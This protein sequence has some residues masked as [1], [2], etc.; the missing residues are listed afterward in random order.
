MRVIFA[1]FFLMLHFERVGRS[2]SDSHEKIRPKDFRQDN[3]Q[4]T[5]ASE[6]GEPLREQ[7]VQRFGSCISKVQSARIGITTSLDFYPS[8]F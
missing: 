6:S 7:R 3:T 1:L 8:Y 5:G 2:S 4:P